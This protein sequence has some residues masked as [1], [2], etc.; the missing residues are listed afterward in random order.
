MALARSLQSLGVPSLSQAPSP[1][2]PSPHPDRAGPLPA[3][4]G[5]G[6]SGNGLVQPL[7]A[8]AIM[9]AI[10]L[11]LG[12]LIAGRV[13]RPVLTMTERLHQISERNVH[14][15]LALPGA[16]NELKDLA[17]TVDGLLGRLETA[18]DTHKRFVANAAHE[19][20]TPL[21]VERAL[22]EEPLIDPGASLESFRSNFERLLVISDQRGQLL[23]SLLALSS[24]EHGRR[25][26]EMVDL[27]ELVELTLRERAAEAE[28]RGLRVQTSLQATRIPGDPVLLGRLLVNL[29]DNTIHHNMS[30][31]T[32]EVSVHRKIGRVVLTVANTG[33]V[34]PSD[35]V[36]R[37]FEPLQRLHRTTDG[38]HNGLGLSIVRA[39]ADAHGATL[40]ARPR[41]EGGLV[42]EVAFSLI[43]ADP[44]SKPYVRLARTSDLWN[45]GRNDPSCST[46]LPGRVRTR[47]ALLLH[48]CPR[49]DRGA[50]A[51]RAR[52]PWRLLVRHA[53]RM[54]AASRGR[55]RL[56][57]GPQGPPG[58]GLARARQVGVATASRRARGPLGRAGGDP[59]PA[60][61]PHLR[62]GGQP[63][64]VPGLGLKRFHRCLESL[65]VP[66]SIVGMPFPAELRRHLHEPSFWAAYFFEPAGAEGPHDDRQLNVEFALGGGC[67]LELDLNL[68]HRYYGLGVLTPAHRSPACVGW[69]DQ[70]HFHPHVFRWEELDQLCRAVALVEP[71]LRHPGPALALLCRYALISDHDDLD[72]VTPLVDGAFTSLRPEGLPADSYWPQ[73]RDWFDRSDLRGAGVTWTRDQYGNWTAHQDDDAGTS[74]PTLYSMRC[75]AE[76]AGDD[77]FPFAAWRE[78]LGRAQQIVDDAVDPRWRAVPEVARALSRITANRDL[79]HAAE[80]G[81]RLAAA[82]CDNTVILSALADPVHP[83]ET[84][85]VL[86]LLTGARPGSLMKVF[87]GPSPLRDARLFRLAL[88]LDVV[89]RPAE[90]GRMVAQ[91]I[92]REL[93]AARLGSATLTGGEARKDWKGSMKWLTDNIV[94]DIRDEFD[95]GVS[96]VGQVL[97]RRNAAGKTDLRHYYKPYDAIRF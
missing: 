9:A 66:H 87:L 39:I 31:G 29:C 41:P 11:F 75:S 51:A 67:G 90:Y 24:S 84:C 47:P 95:A 73:L 88:T 5:D 23:E 8:L 22:L 96:I 58:V 64:G 6:S 68:S 53:R 91:E 12:W 85:W 42:V 10:S 43:A 30:G 35:Q 82:G 18:L 4:D 50:Q 92:D 49:P 54:R 1:P 14:E 45:G 28:R 37:L 71:E 33:E 86:E 80:L 76:S 48:G 74:G 77:G 60:T 65:A 34:I 89:K 72:E 25:A 44:I 83:S 55:G 21:T 15:R 59:G 19:M 57:P 70:V 3:I 56:P 20:R 81:Q 79:T 46:R 38:G 69:D 13:L 32:V 2:P 26:D 17:D 52:R 94:I 16:R 27:A 93:R 62:P 78:V 97:R 36:D 63:A 61:V 40:T 7:I